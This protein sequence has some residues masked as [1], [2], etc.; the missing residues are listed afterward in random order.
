M[1]NNQIDSV[2]DETD[3][4]AF[5]EVAGLV[6]AA[7]GGD[8]A[9][10][11]SLVEQFTPV[12]RGVASQFRL[13]GEDVDDVVQQTWS[14]CVE[15][16]DGL[17]DARA[18]PAWL[19]ATCRHE[20]LRV[21]RWQRRCIPLEADL[22]EAAY[23]PVDAPRQHDPAAAVEQGELVV[24]VRHAVSVLPEH[25]RRLLGGLLRFDG[26]RGAYAEL[27]DLLSMPV[28]S[29]GPTRL[30]AFRRLRQEPVLQGL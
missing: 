29:I 6:S 14:A 5:D 17:R 24:L 27:A 26:V 25:Q 20:C 16:L 8:E 28:G 23:A 19:V 21:L 1:D 4:S 12:L 10:W 30:R 11:A 18:L 13:G 22:V 15:H 3:P 2:A 7:R 9:A